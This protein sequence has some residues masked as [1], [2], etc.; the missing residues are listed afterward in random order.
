M[1]CG[2]SRVQRSSTMSLSHNKEEQ[3]AARFATD[4]DIKKLFS[5]WDFDKSG[6]L[7]VDEI[8]LLIGQLDAEHVITEMDNMHRD[9]QL[10]E[11]EFVAYVHKTCPFIFSD[12]S[13]S[14][15]HN[16][17]AMILEARQKWEHSHPLSV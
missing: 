8:S 5:L 15:L 6:K 11:Q 17:E 12:P 2:G 13:G 10:D 3:A 9:G 4:E 16:L 14:L 7:S 1:G